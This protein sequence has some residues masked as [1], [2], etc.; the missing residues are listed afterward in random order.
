MPDPLFIYLAADEG[1]F[2]LN[3]YQIVRVDGITD[4]QITVH[5]SNGV[6]NTLRGRE[7]VENLKALFAEYT[8]TIDGQ[9]LPEATP[10]GPTLVKPSDTEK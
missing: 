1:S 5:L 3:L 6:S 2:L 10:E 4:D 7:A 9:P 8:M